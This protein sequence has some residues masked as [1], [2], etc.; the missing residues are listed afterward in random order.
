MAEKS[1]RT[2][3]AAASD[4]FIERKSRFIGYC[5]PVSTETEAIAFLEE[6]RKKHRD[7]THNCYAYVLRESH[8]QR[9][10]DDGEP[11]GT[12]GR[13]IL[14]VLLREGLT[15]LCVVVTRYF[16]G[17]LLGAGGLVRAYTEGCKCAIDAA[18]ILAM[19]PAVALSLTMDYAFYGKLQYLL[20][21][22]EALVQG[23]DFGESI[24]QRLLLRQE[25]LPAFQKAVEEASAG[26]VCP[27]VTEE[28]FY[29]FPEG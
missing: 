23:T 25:R 2:I 4:E 26:R 29:P 3:R 28:A 17:I 16:G 14:E 19:H 7:A 22:Y 5:C 13:P 1:Y 15:D 9:F 12:A 21:G 18:E 11:Q 24:T 8:L 6:I 10:S 20:P 27:K